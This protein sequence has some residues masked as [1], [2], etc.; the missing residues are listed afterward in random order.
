MV[1]EKNEE[2]VE[3]G[4]LVLVDVEVATSRATASQPAMTDAT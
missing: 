4:I 3:V 1:I 2:Q